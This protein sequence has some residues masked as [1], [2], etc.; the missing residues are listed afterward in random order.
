M[1]AE[2]VA[3]VTGASSGVGRGIA[4][5]L[6]QAGMR[7]S[8]TGRTIARA[9]LPAEVERV[10]CDH[11]DDEMSGGVRSAFV[12]SQLAAP[13]MIASGRGLM[14]NI[15][16]WAAKKYVGNRPR[17]R[18]TL[19]RPTAARPVRPYGHCRR[20]GGTLW[21]YR[22]RRPPAPATHHRRCVMAVAGPFTRAGRGR[23]LP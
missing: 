12:A 2:G 6:A 22:R 20:A 8:A 15:S 10:A 11:T 16:V 9:D 7:V 17:R 18:R 1:A 14:V 21:V 23:A 19:E 5:A 3:L 13:L 4:D